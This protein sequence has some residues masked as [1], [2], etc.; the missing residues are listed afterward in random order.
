MKHCNAFFIFAIPFLLLGCEATPS[1]KPL[2]A[3]L[4][5]C[6]ATDLTA[7]DII[8]YTG[9]VGSGPGSRWVVFNNTST[10]I[11]A[12]IT[13]LLGNPVPP[14]VFAKPPGVAGQCDIGN[15]TTTSIGGELSL[16]IATLP[17]SGDLK[18]RLAN[19]KVSSVTV[20]G[21]QW[22]SIK[23]DVYNNLI[24]KIPEGSPYRVPGAGRQTAI[25]MLKVKGYTATLDTTSSQSAELNAKYSGELPKALTGDLGGG[26]KAS[27]DNKGKF[28]I[29]IPGET[30]I[31]GIFRPVNAGTGEAQSAKNQKMEV[32]NVSDNPEVVVMDVERRVSVKAPGGS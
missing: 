9:P 23:F 13:D 14:E 5:N 3:A 22:E 29:T 10:A 8:R 4:K 27:V 11:A 30:Y 18:A 26:V 28:Q 12:D 20:N 15:T 16:S 21:Y 19:V 2:I 31:A 17:V 24:S 7:E 25:A 6:A 32:G 1:K